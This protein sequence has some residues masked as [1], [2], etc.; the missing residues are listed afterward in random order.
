VTSNDLAGVEPGRGHIVG[1][2]H[3]ARALGVRQSRAFYPTQFI[4]NYKILFARTLHT[5]VVFRASLSSAVYILFTYYVKHNKKLLYC[6]TD[7]QHT[8]VHWSIYLMIKNVIERHFFFEIK[9]KIKSARST[10]LTEYERIKT[11]NFTQLNSI[12]V[13]HPMFKVISLNSR[14]TTRLISVRELLQ[15]SLS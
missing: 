8:P 9:K 15:F 12:T 2:Q 1:C 10:F 14:H 7:V 3:Y 4:C 6:T 13:L 11:N 5:A